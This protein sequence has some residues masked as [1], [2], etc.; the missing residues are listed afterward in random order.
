M[1]AAN[2]VQRQDFK[3]LKHVQ[4]DKEIGPSLSRCSTLSGSS[5]HPAKDVVE[6]RKPP[7]YTASVPTRAYYSNTSPTH[8]INSP[9]NV[10][11]DDGLF[12]TEEL[13]RFHIKIWARSDED[14]L[15]MLCESMMTDE[16]MWRVLVR[17]LMVCVPGIEEET[18]GLIYDSESAIT[19]ESLEQYTARDNGEYDYLESTI[20][21]NNGPTIR[22]ADTSLCI[23]LATN[24][25]VDLLSPTELRRQ[26]RAMMMLGH[27][28]RHPRPNA[29]YTT[30]NALPAQSHE[31]KVLAATSIV[32]VEVFRLALRIRPAEGPPQTW[33]GARQA[34][35]PSRVIHT[36]PKGTMALGPWP[37]QQVCR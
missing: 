22:Y 15:A 18:S 10:T 13:L 36:H 2:P 34:L 27:P 6:S 37:G 16:G 12:Y 8:P 33:Q 5:N 3:S 7:A 23:L 26:R 4:R 29:G 9:G 31:H 11:G 19:F 30:N 17:R 35:P 28:F 24:E 32:L 1:K 25:V 21:A 20:A 14:V